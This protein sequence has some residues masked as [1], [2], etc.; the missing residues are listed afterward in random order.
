V[1]IAQ[2]E[3]LEEAKSLAGKCPPSDSD[4]FSSVELWKNAPGLSSL[5]R[6]KSSSDAL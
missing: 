4:P 6:E 2:I 3:D 5:K 1:L